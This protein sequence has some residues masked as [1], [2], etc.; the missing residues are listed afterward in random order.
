M[1]E[2]F[3]CAVSLKREPLTVDT[4]VEHESPTHLEAEEVALQPEGDD[5]QDDAQQHRDDVEDCVDG[6]LQDL[7]LV[8]VLASSIEVEDGP[9]NQHRY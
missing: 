3:C 8:D 4:H 9:R 7:L 1:T 5:L 2:T 6:P